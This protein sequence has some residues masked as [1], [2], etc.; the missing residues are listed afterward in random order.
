MI[1]FDI[2]I[3]R[4]TFVVKAQGTLQEGITTLMGP[5]GS[6]K[7]TFLKALCGLLTPKE[8]RITANN[9]VW[10]EKGT[11][12]PTQERHIG[13]MPQGNIVFPHM[14]VEENIRYSKQG[15]PEL[16]DHIVERLRLTPHLKKKAKG[17]SGG[18]QQRVALG[19]ALYSKPVLLI[20]D[21]PLTALDV[22]LR[23]QLQQDLVAIIS[24]WAIPCLWVTHSEEEAAAVGNH[25]LLCRDG[26]IA[27]ET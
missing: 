4:G 24:E 2:V 19:R 12:V 23:A 17:L 7:S 22:N 13:Y 10:F 26:V 27:E 15:S 11:G 6:G 18:E 5:S 14:T 8:G 21:E 25:R 20:L 1:S 9:E 16:F 3:E